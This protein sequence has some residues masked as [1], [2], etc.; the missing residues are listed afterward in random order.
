MKKDDF[1]RIDINFKKE[2]DNIKLERIKVSSDKELKSY[3][4]IT[5]AIPRHRL[6]KDI[7]LD[8][9]KAELPDIKL[10]PGRKRGTI[11]NKLRK[12]KPKKK[13]KRGQENLF[14]P[15]FFIIT[16]FAIILLYGLFVYGM[17]LFTEGIETVDNLGGQV[18]ATEAI[19]DTFGAFNDSLLPGLK[20]V[21]MGII[22]G[23]IL[24]AFLSAYFVEE[25]P[26]F[27]I[28]YILVAVIAVI[29]S[30]YISNSY[31]LLLEG[32]AFSSTL[33]QFTVGNHILLYLPLYVTIISLGSLIF[34]FIKQRRNEFA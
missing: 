18:N 26:A 15:I 33:R 29:I 21:S 6:W 9:I 24:F 23:L 14:F 7:K 27:V 16:I 8:I 20:L 17:N 12:I 13:N 32:E 1:A 11:V 25:H 30:V 34:L 10:K 2:L 3:R 19:G 28:I 22:F 5:Q 4:R 31:H